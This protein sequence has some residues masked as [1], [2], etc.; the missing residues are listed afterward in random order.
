M[1]VRRPA[2]HEFDAGRDRKRS[3]SIS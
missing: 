3:T 1:A 2:D